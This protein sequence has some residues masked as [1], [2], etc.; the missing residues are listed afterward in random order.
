MTVFE[1]LTKSPQALGS[2]LR[3]LPVLEAP[4]DT[5]FQKRFC[6]GC[7]AEDCDACQNQKYRNNP[8]WWL[9]VEA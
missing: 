8:D 4:W 3:S 9:T 6:A 7:A 5:E 2:F 1:E